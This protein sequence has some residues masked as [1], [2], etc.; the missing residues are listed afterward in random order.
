MLEGILLHMLKGVPGGRIDIA[1]V[2]DLGWNKRLFCILERDYPYKVW[3]AY[4]QPTTLYMSVP[5]YTTNGATIT[6]VP[7]YSSIQ[8]I[9]SRYKTQDDAINEV[10]EI[11]QKQKK[12]EEYKRQLEQKI[13]D[14]Q[15]LN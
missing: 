8:I 2:I 15:K 10:L 12:I 11:K 4:N 1:K 6:I 5:T 9:E 13:L 3:I 14:I 7:T